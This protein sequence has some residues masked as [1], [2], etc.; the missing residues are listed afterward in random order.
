MPIIFGEFPINEFLKLKDILLDNGF[1]FNDF[2]KLYFFKSKRW[3]LIYDNKIII[4]LPINQK[5]FSMKILKKI[6]ENL[7]LDDIKTIDLR[8]SDRIIVL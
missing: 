2:N 8:I 7:N 5:D 1:E 6:F 3:D 4:K